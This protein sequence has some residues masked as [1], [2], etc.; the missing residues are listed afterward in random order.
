MISPKNGPAI[1]GPAGP[2]PVLSLQ[3]HAA[4]VPQVLHYNYIIYIRSSTV[5]LV[6]QQ[7]S[8]VPVVGGGEVDSTFCICVSMRR[9][10]V[11]IQNYVHVHV[12]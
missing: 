9:G 4:T 5:Q 12:E 2:D 10:H 1:A 8:A 11:R 7:G 3:L 6:Q